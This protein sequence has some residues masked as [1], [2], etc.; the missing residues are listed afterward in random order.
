M[1]TCHD[2]KGEGWIPV[3]PERQRGAQTVAAPTASN[4]PGELAEQPPD[5][6]PWGTPPDHPDYGRMPQYRS[7]PL[8]A[9]QG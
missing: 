8:P 4:G 2:C 3:G 7:H 9:P 6:D 5:L 1:L